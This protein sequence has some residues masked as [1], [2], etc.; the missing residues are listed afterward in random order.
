[1][2]D[3]ITM[4]FIKNKL[5]E[6]GYEL[7][8]END[9]KNNKTK[10]TFRDNEGYIYYQSYNSFYKGV[11]SLK[12]SSSNP[13]SIVNIKN[14][15]KINNIDLEILTEKYISSKDKLL[16][17]CSCGEIFKVSMGA[18][19]WDG[20]TK[21]NKCSKKEKWSIE[22]IKDY[23]K[24]NDIKVELLSTEI[25]NMDKPL[26]WK[27][28]CGNIYNC[29]IHH[30]IG[31]KQYRCLSCAKTQSKYEHL[32]EEYLKEQKIN[33]RTEYKFEDCKNI[34]SLPFDFAI[35]D[36]Y[37]NLKLL[38][39]ADGEQHYTPK[40]YVTF[41]NEE[42]RLEKFKKRQKLDNIKNQ[43]CKDNNI[44]LIRIPYWEF[45]NSNYLNILKEYL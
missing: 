22:K 28:K 44:K 12:W 36:E 8:N 6:S 17:R 27:C 21:C 15:L 7:L 26:I 4:D 5:K 20:K 32:I 14:Y 1:M 3:K 45:K 18:I 40:H 33:Y 43:Y 37:G 30:F 31:A 11:K 25:I 29:S 19:L 2:S 9:Y 41:N 24:D 42:E 13:Y 39:E 38:I 34:R 10:L 16:F 23:I 35:F